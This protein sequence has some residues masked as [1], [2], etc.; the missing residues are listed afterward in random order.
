MQTLSPCEKDLAP[1][2]SCA[3][4]LWVPQP[5]PQAPDA[6]EPALPSAKMVG[7]NE[8]GAGAAIIEAGSG[9]GSRNT[10]RV[11]GPTRAA[12]PSLFSGQR[13]AACAFSFVATD[14][15]GRSRKMETGA[16][17]AEAGA[18]KGEKLNVAK[19]N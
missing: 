1:L 11:T 9:S 7:E 14:S 3:A 2:Q 8:P 4:A 16:G 10:A 19:K 17:A 18:G 15:V 13:P 6:R 12:P 5:W